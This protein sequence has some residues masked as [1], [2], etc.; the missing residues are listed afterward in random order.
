MNMD[1]YINNLLQSESSA[2]RRYFNAEYINQIVQLHKDRKENY[3]RQLNML[4]AF[5]LWHDKFLGSS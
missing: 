4:I 2:V 5:E 1:S 3:M